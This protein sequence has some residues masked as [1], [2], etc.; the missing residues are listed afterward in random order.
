MNRIKLHTHE[1]WI[2]L[3]DGPEFVAGKAW[4]LEQAQH[5]QAQLVS[6]AKKAGWRYVYTIREVL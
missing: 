1:V 6:C 4:T 3:P 2:K 5:I